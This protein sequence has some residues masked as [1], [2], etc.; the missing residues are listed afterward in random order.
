MPKVTVVCY[1]FSLLF[2][3]MGYSKTLVIKNAVAEHL[4]TYDFTIYVSLATGYFVLT[5]FFAVIGSL[6]FYVKHKGDQGIKALN[7]TELRI[8]AGKGV[9]TRRRGS[10]LN[11][12]AQLPQS[13]YALDLNRR[14]SS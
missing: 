11:V 3:G 2:Y 14:M 7:N 5:I 10:R 4:N 6:V 13:E 1:L 9:C 8:I 12:K